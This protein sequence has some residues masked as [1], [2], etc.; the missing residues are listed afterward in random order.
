MPRSTVVC[1]WSSP[2]ECRPAEPRA[3][4][5]GSGGGF[6]LRDLGVI[7]AGTLSAAKARLLLMLLLARGQD[8]VRERF[9]DAAQT[10]AA[11]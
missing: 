8:D 9:T 3:V 11:W 4:Y 7:E 2:R 6:T 1:R 10:L 5:G